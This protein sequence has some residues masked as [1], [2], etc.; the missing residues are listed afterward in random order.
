VLEHF[1]DEDL[2]QAFYKFFRELADLYEILSPDAFLRPYIDDYDQ[3][4]RM[5]KVL[6]SAYDSVFVD[7]ELTR[8]TAQLVQE[9]TH[10]GAIQDSFTDL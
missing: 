9:H 7:K 2:R 1:R 8:K 4:S 10:S 5:Y 3:L 6:R